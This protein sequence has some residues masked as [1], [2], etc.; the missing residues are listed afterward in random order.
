MLGASLFIELKY[1]EQAFDE[2]IEKIFNLAEKVDSESISVG[3]AAVGNLLGGIR[4]FYGQSKIALSR[5]LNDI[6]HC[7]FTNNVVQLVLGFWFWVSDKLSKL[8]EQC[9]LLQNGI[10]KKLFVYF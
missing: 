2:K 1:K 10:D 3:K 9:N 4:Y 7:L 8:L 5:T 6:C